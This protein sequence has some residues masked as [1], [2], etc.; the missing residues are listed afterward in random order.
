MPA[1]IRQSACMA[2][3]TEAGLPGGLPPSPAL[4]RRMAGTAWKIRVPYQ[5]LPPV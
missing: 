5:A 4:S 2:R 1:H 3:R